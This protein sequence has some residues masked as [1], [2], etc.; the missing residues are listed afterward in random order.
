M[1]YQRK[2]WTICSLMRC[3]LTDSVIVR[4]MNVLHEQFPLVHG[5]SF[6]RPIQAEES[7][8]RTVTTDDAHHT[9]VP[10]TKKDPYIQILKTKL[11]HWITCCYKAKSKRNN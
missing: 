6:A 4:A 2:F 9:Y 8:V 10:C 7:L 5:H 1:L 11:S 3:L